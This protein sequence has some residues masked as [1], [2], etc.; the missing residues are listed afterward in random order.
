MT[1][2]DKQAAEEIAAL[3]KEVE[4]L[5]AAQPKP[6]PEF[7]ERPCQR[8]AP[9]E[10]MSMPPSALRAM[11]EAV[12]AN[13]MRDVV[14]DNRAPRTPATIPT[15]QQSTGGGPASGSGTGW[16][17]STPLSPPPGV[18]QADRLMDAQDAK[19]RA[20]LVEREAKLQ[21]MEKLAEGK[22]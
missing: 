8:Y 15:S 19:D 17:H 22:P 12:P 20:E 7:K 10:G 6:E 18:A 4:A 11:V 13:F 2:V 5:K 3:R 1:K 16:G 14:R 21:A 9:T